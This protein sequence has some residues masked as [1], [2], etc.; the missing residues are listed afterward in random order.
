MEAYS[1]GVLSR[2]HLVY[3]ELLMEAGPIELLSEL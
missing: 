2:R 1:R 3:V